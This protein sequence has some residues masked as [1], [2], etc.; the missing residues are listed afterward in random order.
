MFVLAK[1]AVVWQILSGEVLAGL[2][3]HA[4][5]QGVGIVLNLDFFAKI[6]RRRY[7]LGVVLRLLS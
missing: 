7:D 3:S 2:A 4:L 1:D 6:I 5:A